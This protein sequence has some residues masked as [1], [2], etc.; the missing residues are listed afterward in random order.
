M[1][2]I[3]ENKKLLGLYIL[4]ITLHISFFIFSAQGKKYEFWPW[5]DYSLVESYDITE[6]IIYCMFPALLIV[7]F[8]LLINNKNGDTK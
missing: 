2:S 6:L 8:N 3:L 4:W 5:T 1:K 7:S